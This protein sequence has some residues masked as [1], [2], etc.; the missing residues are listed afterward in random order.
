MVIANISGKKPLINDEKTYNNGQTV[1]PSTYE[2]ES[3]Q[4]ARGV[5]AQWLLQSRPIPVV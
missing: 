2:G 5:G 1:V 3:E 4:L